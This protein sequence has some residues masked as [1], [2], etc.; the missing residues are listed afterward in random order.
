MKIKFI[1][2]LF[3]FTFLFSCKKSERV[4]EPVTTQQ[5]VVN[6]TKIE[7]PNQVL[8]ADG[9]FYGTEQSVRDSLNKKIL[10]KSEILTKEENDFFCNCFIKE[11]RSSNDS[12]SILQT[13]LNKCGKLL[14]IQRTERKPGFY[15]Y[16]KDGEFI[17]TLASLKKNILKELKAKKISKIPDEYLDRV[18]SCI[19]EKY[20]NMTSKQIDNHKGI[21]DECMLEKF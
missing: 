4:S 12:D 5:E 14:R 2:I 13:S 18:I 15:I 21:F 9:K 7:I 10:G 19:G 6:E 16:S 8:T 3:I 17:G 1:S 11:V 20:S